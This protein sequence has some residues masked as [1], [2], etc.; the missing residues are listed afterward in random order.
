MRRNH[1]ELLK[2]Q[3]DGTVHDGMRDDAATASPTA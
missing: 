2:H 1:M 3:R